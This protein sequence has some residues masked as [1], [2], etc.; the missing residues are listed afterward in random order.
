M[1]TGREN[2]HSAC[3]GPGAQKKPEDGKPAVFPL[4]ALAKTYVQEALPRPQERKG[5]ALNMVGA[6]TSSS[7]TLPEVARVEHS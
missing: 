4:Q 1:G 7:E 2:T 5:Q 3:S 6:V